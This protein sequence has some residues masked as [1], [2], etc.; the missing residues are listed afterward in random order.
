MWGRGGWERPFCRVAALPQHAFRHGHN[1]HYGP[2]KWRGLFF[3]KLLNKVLATVS[4]LTEFFKSGL[5]V[6][7]VIPVLILCYLICLPSDHLA[8]LVHRA[9]RINMLNGRMPKSTF[10]N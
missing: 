6:A 5:V 7:A 2:D 4:S 3:H 10:I 1:R 8:G 9:C